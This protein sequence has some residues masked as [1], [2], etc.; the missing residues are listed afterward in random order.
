MTLVI[1]SSILAVALFCLATTGAAQYFGR[2]KVQYETFDF[3]ILTTEHFRIYFYAGEQ[4]A[5]QQASR[6]AERWYERL[7]R[8]LSH[9]LRG[10]QSLILYAD[11][12]DF[13]QTNVISGEISEATG[14]VTESLKRRI[15]LPLGASLAETDHVIGHEL[16]HAFQY[17]ITG[18]GNGGSAVLPGAARLPLWFIEGMAEYLS[19]GRDDPHTAMWMRDAVARDKLPRFSDLASPEYFPYRWG[20]AFWAFLTGTYG[21]EIVS[22][23]LRTAGKSGDVRV[24]LQQLTSRNADSLVA[25]WHKALRAAAEPVRRATDSAVAGAQVVVGGSGEGR[26]NLGPALS[27]DGRRL[28]YLSERGLFSIDMYLADAATGRTIRR[29]VETARDPHF[30]SL[31]FVSSAG[32]W[33]A[34]GRRFAF[35]AVVRGRPVLTIVDVIA[36]RIEREISLPEVG[37][38]FTP[39][40]SPEGGAIAFTGQAG[41]F[42][43]L[44]LYDL[45][46]GVLRRLTEDAFADLQPAWSPDGASIAFATDR[47]T[48]SLATLDP[49]ATRLATLDVAS[50]RISALPALGSAK[51][52]N[53]QW[54]PDGQ[55][56]YFLSDHG[57]V[58]NVYRL[59]VA[60]RRLVQLTD[61]FTGVSGI[62][63]LSPA[64][65]VAQQSGTIAFT[66]YARGGYALYIV[67]RP[68]A[69]FVDPRSSLPVATSTLPPSTPAAGDSLARLLA[70]AEVG[71]PPDTAYTPT[72]YRAG[73]SLDFIAQPS[74]AVAVDRFGAFFG[75][76]ATLFWSD[77]LGDHNLVT[78]LQVSGSFDNLSALVGYE[79][80]RTQLN[81]GVAAQQIPFVFGSIATG[82]AQID[83]EDVFVEQIETLRQTNRDLAGVVAYPFDR[84]RR[85]EL[86]AG[87]RHISFSRELQE[88]V[89]SLA[90]GEPIIDRTIDLGAPEALLLGVGS[91]ALVHDASFFGATSPILGD[92]WRLEAAPTFGSLSFVTALADYRRYIMPV[93]PFTLA[94]RLLHVGRYGGSAEDER[95]SPLFLGFPS[96]VRG[97]DFGSFSV[98]DCPA[99][100]S[101]GCPALD[102]L[103]G[104]KLLVANT[105]LR[106]PLFGVL[107]VGDGYYGFLPVE[108]ALF[109]DAGVAWTDGTEPRLFG[110]DRR[111]MT[112]AG[113][114]L[115]MN[116][117][118]FAIGQLD[119][120]RPFA[121]EKG[122]MIQ[123]SLTPGF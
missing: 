57:G 61:L 72:P 19:L 2:N 86:S 43:D 107:G 83:G 105:E 112:S 103:F 90:T 9:Q 25:D 42:T 109:Y 10:K 50:G 76:G 117:F 104:S 37:E 87:L 30:E 94:G 80:R 62:T 66:V 48:T 40:W 54:S 11:H 85:L 106:F 88:R 38:I 24:A 33:D 14:G 16:V 35:G 75:G 47:F 101:R 74:L 36:D 120:V 63:T 110:G 82:V 102:Q 64:L 29:L 22:R 45:E 96:L 111:L 98:D 78:G 13:E 84:S 55:G 70:D 32:A 97:Y 89:F 108:A 95:I 115:R 93:R 18:A 116:L 123:A 17:D 44:Y 121:R 122:W 34:Q 23:A 46:R 81:W 3:K 58:T 79:N 53:P 28:V 49:G 68:E 21:D 4:P 114:S 91:A 5:A 26:L 56:L 71:L 1:R 12:P 20:Q 27:P 77:M 92:R 67:E 73:V 119:Y 69:L 65:S 15:V 8:V 6:M 51:H 118:G 100:L 113:V 39:T 59:T 99:D 60:D 41:G 31:Q 7:S 52:I